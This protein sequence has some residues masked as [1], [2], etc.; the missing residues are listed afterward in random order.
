MYGWT[1]QHENV[2]D[3][4]RSNYRIASALWR[5]T[6]IDAS[7]FREWMVSI[8]RRDAYARLAHILCEMLVRMRAVGLVGEDHTCEFPISQGKIA[9]AQGLSAVHVNR[10]L[11]ELRAAKLI[12]LKGGVLSV[13][14]W[15]GLKKAGQFDATYLHLE[16]KKLAA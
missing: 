10:V 13:L 8:G 3:L 5:E 14:D 6:L 9:D 15:D 4:C 11:Q 2:H 16:N 12:T 7:I 1:I